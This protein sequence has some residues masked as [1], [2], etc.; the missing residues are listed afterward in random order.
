MR[1]YY[2]ARA[3]EYDRIYL[4]PERQQDLRAIERWLPSVFGGRSVLEIAC[5]TGYWTQF[6][7]P[8][9]R[10]IL[11]ID[12]SSETLQIAR[13]RISADTVEFTVGDAYRLP[14]STREFDACF[15]GFWFSHVPHTQMRDFLLGLHKALLPGAK[16]VF[17]DNRFVTGSSTP[18]SETDADGNTYQ[19]RHLEGGSAHR[20]LK[21]F[22]SHDDL[23]EAVSDVAGDIHF[24]EWQYYWALEYAIAAP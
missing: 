10:R 8:A 9:A 7:A 23:R 4:K 20:V 11:A 22:P 2:A 24:H 15:A 12:A 3:P 13:N 17:L 1:E 21:N 14:A 18:I 19:I 5:G 16:V 6:L